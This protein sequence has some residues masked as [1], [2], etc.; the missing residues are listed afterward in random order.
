[1]RATPLLRC[2]GAPR[3]LGLDQGRA[4]RDAIRADARAAGF[5]APE[6]LL[7]RVRV[8]RR[9]TAPGRSAL[10]RDL[11]RHF[12]HLAERAAGLAAGAG[13]GEAALLDA[14]ARE[15]DGDADGALRCEVGVADDA[16]VLRIAEPWPLTGFA[17][18]E[19]APD[20]GHRNLGFTRP[21][22]LGSF[23]GVNEHGLAGVAMPLAAPAQGERCAAPGI[24]LLDQCIERLD[25]VEKALEWCEHRPGGGRALLLFADATGARAALEIDG[26]KRHRRAAPPAAGSGLAVRVLPRARS[27]AV[28]GAGIEAVRF[29]LDDRSR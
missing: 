25:S 14:L 19:C 20:G 7:E 21:A 9:D 18:R 16:L 26:E 27:L 29:A 8:S 17:V 23:A 22:Q 10:A 5:P 6:T 12:P 13:V 24:L 11:M 28:D 1:M 2:A 3:D 15:L 4:A